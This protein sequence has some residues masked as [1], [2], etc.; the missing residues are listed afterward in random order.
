MRILHT[1]DLHGRYKPLLRALAAGDYDIWVD[2][3]DFFPNKTPLGSPDE[4]RFVQPRWQAR[5]FGFKQL[6]YRLAEAL[7]GRPMVSVS[8]NHDFTRFANQLRS[9]G[10]DA[11]Q[12]EAGD[13]LELLG[14][15]IAGFREVPEDEG[16]W[17]GE[18]PQD[19]FA[20]L[21]ATT[22][23]L[24][25]SLLLTHAPPGG[26]LDDVAED[27]HIGVM[28]LTDWLGSRAHGVRAHLFGH[29]HRHGG[30][31][32]E[33]HGLRFINGATQIRVLELD[34]QGSQGAGASP[35]SRSSRSTPVGLL[36]VRE[37]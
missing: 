18:L 33:R 34:L 7:D 1:S 25:P 10:A 35:T 8:G 16:R 5:W 24:G 19:A 30:Q 6:K 9:A 37:T 12:L 31:E 26:I 27:G 23:A 4:M 13:C 17:M 20:E 28:A 29:T 14:Q 11:R 22:E 21:V 15:R 36:K 3:G 32:V 2:T